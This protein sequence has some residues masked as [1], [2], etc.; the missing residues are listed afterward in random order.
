M[1]INLNNKNAFFGHSCGI[2]KWRNLQKKHNVG[3]IWIFFMQWSLFFNPDESSSFTRRIILI[4]FSCWPTAFRVSV[5]KYPFDPLQIYSISSRTYIYIT[6]LYNSVYIYVPDVID[7]YTVRL[8][9]IFTH[10]HW[11]KKI[12]ATPFWGELTYYLFSCECSIYGY[13][14]I[15]LCF[16]LI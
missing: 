2:W 7:S 1:S 3:L 12:V 11:R 5:K 13:V 6:S 9:V 14:R 16:S 15:F 10:A 4:I 8:A